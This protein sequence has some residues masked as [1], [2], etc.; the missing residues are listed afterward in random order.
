MCPRDCSS[1]PEL[2]DGSDRI[3]CRCLR[4][5]EAAI[6]GAVDQ[7]GLTT[8]VEIKCHTEAGTGCTACHKRICRLLA[9][10]AAAGRITLET[11]AAG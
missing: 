5:T 7:F 3:I 6:L 2:A 4:V 10:C 1:C 11:R 8:L 9:E